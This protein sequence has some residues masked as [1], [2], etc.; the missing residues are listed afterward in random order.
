[1]SVRKKEGKKKKKEERVL[2]RAWEKKKKSEDPSSRSVRPSP[3]SARGGNPSPHL[4]G[5]GGGE[6][7]AK[8]R[9]FFPPSLQVGNF[10]RWELKVL[11][12]FE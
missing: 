5:K 12:F 8:F 6:P 3:A 10:H 11:Y 4:P 1:M 7:L 9:F 2:K